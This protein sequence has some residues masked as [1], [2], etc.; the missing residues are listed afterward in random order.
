MRPCQKNLTLQKH[1]AKFYFEQRTLWHEEYRKSIEGD[2]CTQELTI[3]ALDFQGNVVETFRFSLK[4][5][6]STLLTLV[7]WEDFEKLED[8]EGWTAPYQTGY[9]DGWMYRFVC[10]NER[11]EPV[12]SRVLEVRFEKGHEPADESLLR[13]VK[14]GYSNRKA[15]KQYGSLW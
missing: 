14:N 13:W 6:M 12:L 3:K 9:R 4:D 7:R 11:G 2:L 1:I 10:M 15:L 8:F 5:K